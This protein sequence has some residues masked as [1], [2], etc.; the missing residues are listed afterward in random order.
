[1]DRAPLRHTPNDFD[2]IFG[3]TVGQVH[4]DDDACDALRS[5]RQLRRETHVHVADVSVPNP[6]NVPFNVALSFPIPLAASV[7]T[8]NAGGGGGSLLPQPA[9][10]ML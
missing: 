6:V 7:S 10:D 5:I 8:S 9:I 2:L 3:H 4:V 1:M